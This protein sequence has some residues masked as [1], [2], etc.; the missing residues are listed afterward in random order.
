MNETK[1]SEIK[2]NGTGIQMKKTGEGF[3][4]HCAENSRGSVLLR[5][6]SSDSRI[7][8]EKNSNIE[9]TILVEP[10]A[11]EK[12]SFT[13]ELSGEKAELR[14]NCG[15]KASGEQNLDITMNV[16]HKAPETKSRTNVRGVLSGSAKSVFHGNIRVERNAAKSDSHLMH[17]VLAFDSAKAYAIPSLEIKNNDV[18]SSHGFSLSQLSEQDLFYIM[19]RGI[20]QDE[21]KKLAIKGF[22]EPVNK[23]ER[24]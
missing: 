3:A 18:K 6:S 2:I 20:S 12:I 8:L 16:T 21:A 23:A 7:V 11:A 14:T 24:W 15:F 9:L 17:K 4:L 10:L 22:L 1:M 13:A 19:S 5:T